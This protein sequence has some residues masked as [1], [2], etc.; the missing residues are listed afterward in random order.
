MR[1]CSGINPPRHEGDDD[2]RGNGGRG[3]RDG[4]EENNPLLYEIGRKTRRLQARSGKKRPP[5][6]R[7]RAHFVAAEG[8]GE[9]EGR[10][11]D[12][13]VSPPLRAWEE[14]EEEADKQNSRERLFAVAQMEKWARV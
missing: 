1:A 6:V 9:G 5:R 4:G 2:E 11:L 3:R 13:Q 8:G 14:E 12:A 7:A 10:N